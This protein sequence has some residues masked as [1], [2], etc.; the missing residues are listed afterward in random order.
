MRSE[1]HPLAC[2]GNR[3]TQPVLTSPIGT[4]S[5]EHHRASASRLYSPLPVT[6]RIKLSF[7]PVPSR[8]LIPRFPSLT[9]S[10]RTGRISRLHPTGTFQCQGSDLRPSKDPR[11][12]L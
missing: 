11:A 7:Q 10:S 9:P 1:T 6:R 12:L 3:P 8:F 5:M 4:V 2:T